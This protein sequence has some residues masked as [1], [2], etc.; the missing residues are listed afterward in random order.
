VALLQLLTMRIP[1]T[2]VV[3]YFVYQL[4]QGIDAG[5]AYLI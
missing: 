4:Y 1:I 3:G 2:I 5:I